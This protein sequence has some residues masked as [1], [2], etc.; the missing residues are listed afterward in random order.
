ATRCIGACGLA[1]VMTVNGDVYG[2]ITP[3][4]V[5]GIIKKYL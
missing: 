3:A 1:P 4:D 2:R 5:E